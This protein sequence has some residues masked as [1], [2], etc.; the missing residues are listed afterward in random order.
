MGYRSGYVM[1]DEE[2][3]GWA[4][5]W[6]AYPR[7][8]SK[9]D[10]RKAWA[11]INPSP[12][13]VQKMLDALAWQ[14]NQPQWTKDDGCYI[15]HA[16]S[17]LNGEKWEDEC[18]ASLRPAKAYQPWSLESCPHEEP[19]EQRHHCEFR[20]VNPAKYPLKRGAA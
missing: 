20:R 18:P 16:S 12:D 15:P 11:R 4:S 5:F 3:K 1:V 6:A 8:Q 17:W 9:K 13:M 2:D 14:V 10:A 7:R 19:C